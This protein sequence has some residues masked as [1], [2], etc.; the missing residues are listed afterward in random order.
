MARYSFQEHKIEHND[1]QILTVEDNKVNQKV[2]ILT[3][4]KLGC[5]VDAAR[6]RLDA[7]NLL[8]KKP[9]DIVFMVRT[10]RK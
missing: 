9:C 1:L 7:I 5:Q 4:E 3:L 10:N 8:Q 2:T 6:N